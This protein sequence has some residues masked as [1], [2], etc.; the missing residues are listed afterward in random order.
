MP[1]VSKRDH[2]VT[3]AEELFLDQGFKGTSIDLVVTTCRVSRPTV[4]RHFPDKAHLM[5]AVMEAWLDRQQE[6]TVPGSSDVPAWVR[7]ARSHWWS[8]DA[9]AMY[10]LVVSEGWRFPAAARSFWLRY[11]QRWQKAA[12]HEAGPEV[13][14]HLEAALWRTLRSRASDALPD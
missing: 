7:H 1:Q 12:A 14:I 5:D 2:I 6:F 10:A 11:D 13:L 9:M 3:S 8:A 4:Y